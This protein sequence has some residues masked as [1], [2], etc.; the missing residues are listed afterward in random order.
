MVDPRFLPGFVVVGLVSAIA[1]A[2]LL[3][4]G[5]SW[6]GPRRAGL[7]A[8]ALPLALLAP[9][10]ATSYSSWKLV[11]LFSG[12]AQE[13]PPGAMRS[14]LDGFASLWFLERAGWGAFGASCIVGLLLGLL[15]FGTSADDVACSGRRGFALL[16]L[17]VLGLAAAGVTTQRLAT[18]VRVSAAVIS[19]DEKDPA[20][21]R[22]SEAVLEAAGLPTKGSGSIAATSTYI[23][24][25][26]MT[27]VFGGAAAAVILLGLALPGFILAWRVR[28]GATFT[29]LAT[30]L[31]LLA[32][33]GAAVVCFGVVDPLRL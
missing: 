27:G 17:P 30:L 2:T 12:M 7:V 19:S 23:A 8:G 18:A 14:L 9:A 4:I 1:F 5:V 25:A 11:G 26:M 22:R 3:A 32:A 13:Q 16:L 15:R 33:A 6:P 21:Q 20:S 28:F 29:A 31:W 24:R 10:V